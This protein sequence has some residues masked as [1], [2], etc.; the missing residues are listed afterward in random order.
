MRQGRPQHTPGLR[1]DEGDQMHSRT[2]RM[3]RPQPGD[4]P[5]LSP[6]QA[7]P[8][9]SKASFFSSSKSQPSNSVL[10][11]QKKNGV[12][13]TSSVLQAEAVSPHQAH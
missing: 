5:L 7:I 1:A 12:N 11:T 4:A 13:P 2:R 8:Q 3:L 10:T 9:L 6:P